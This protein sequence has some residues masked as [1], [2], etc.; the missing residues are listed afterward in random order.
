MEY[1][2]RSMLQIFDEI[3]SLAEQARLQ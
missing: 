1:E 3:I 2:L